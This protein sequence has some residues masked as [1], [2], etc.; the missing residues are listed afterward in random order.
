VA[1]NLREPKL[2]SKPYTPPAW[3]RPAAELMARNSLSLKQAV[4]ELKVQITPEE[5]ELVSRR[6][7]FQQILREE[8]NKFHTEVADQPGRN[9]S[10]ALGMMQVAIEKLMVEGEW[11]KAVAAIEKLAKLEG[12]V[13]SDS[14]INIFS[15]LTA[16]DI[17]EAKERISKQIEP[18][19]PQEI[20][21]N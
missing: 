2:P 15:G 16:R 14:N 4:S 3:Y 1:S 7:E 13:G 10:T 5:C 11:D 8:R 9:K 21:P 12:W 19:S 18:R 17:A 6:K 20:L